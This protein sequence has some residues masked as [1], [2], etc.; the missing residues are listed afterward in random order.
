MRI[1][2]KQITSSNEKKEYRNRLMAWLNRLLS[3]SG[4]YPLAAFV[5]MWPLFG[6]I[7]A[8]LVLFGQQPDAAI[9]AFTDTSDWLFSQKVSPPPIVGIP[10][11]YLCTAAARGHKRIVKPIRKGLRGKTEIIVN[12]QLCVANA[13]EELLQEKTPRFR[14]LVRR[15][16]DAIGC[17]I[18]RRI[19]TPLAADIAYIIIKPLEWI[20][21]LILYIVE[22]KPENRIAR[23]YL[24]NR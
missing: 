2:I 22:V 3:K 9:R 15:I 11:E 4:Y 5:L 14:R 21:T 17:P 13:F 16:Y 8:V 1:V 20:M 12:R 23:Q 7:T 19:R 10:A 24:P 18:A 6:I